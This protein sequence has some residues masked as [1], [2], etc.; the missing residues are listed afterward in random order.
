MTC[1]IMGRIAGMASIGEREAWPSPI[2]MAIKRF[3]HIVSARAIFLGITFCIIGLIM[4]HSW[5]AGITSNL[6][7]MIGII[8]A[9]VPEGLLAPVKVALTAARKLKQK[10]VK[11][12][13][14]EVVETLGLTTCIC[15]DKTGTLT[16]NK[17]TASFLYLE[18]E[19]KPSS[20]PDRND[21]YNYGSNCWDGFNW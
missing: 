6:L 16:Q 12:K 7:F 13:N 5:P 9:N 8:F 15:S 3:I 14:L 21:L 18:M 11:V 1:T 20:F 10:N 17:M 2:E 4:D 19:N